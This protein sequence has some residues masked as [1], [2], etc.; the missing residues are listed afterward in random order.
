MRNFEVDLETGIAVVEGSPDLAALFH[1]LEGTSGFS[2]GSF[3]LILLPSH[4]KKMATYLF[5]HEKKEFNSKP[6]N[7]DPNAQ[8][9]QLSTIGY[10]IQ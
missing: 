7:N 5:W 2:F 4:S 6:P 8:K 10:F 1:T 3:L 9:V